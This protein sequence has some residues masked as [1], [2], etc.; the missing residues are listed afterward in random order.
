MRTRYLIVFKNGDRRVVDKHFKINDWVFGLTVHKLTDV[1]KLEG[2]AETIAFSCPESNVEYV[3]EMPVSH[4]MML[5]FND[6]YTSIA[7]DEDV[8]I[9]PEELRA[10]RRE[11]DEIDK[12]Y[13]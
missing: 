3:E 5:T 1:E 7:A 12:V 11:A 8:D 2:L 6:I 13:G 10:M 4:A 9:S